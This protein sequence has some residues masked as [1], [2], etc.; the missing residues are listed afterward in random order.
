MIEKI[1]KQHITMGI[2][3]LIVVAIGLFIVNQFVSFQYKA[4]LLADPCYVCVEEHGY[5]CQKF[6]QQLPGLKINL[7]NIIINPPN[8]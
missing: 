4:Q 1:T 2:T 6:H 7:S 3:I 5:E 8:G